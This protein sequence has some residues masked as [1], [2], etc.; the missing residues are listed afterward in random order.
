M[1]SATSTTTTTSRRSLHILLLGGSP[2]PAAALLLKENNPRQ[3]PCLSWST[4]L[5]LESSAR[6]MSNYRY[7]WW[8]WSQLLFWFKQHPISTERSISVA[9]FYVDSASIFLCGCSQHITCEFTNSSTYR[10]SLRL[11]LSRAPTSS[12]GCWRQSVWGFLFWYFF[13]AH[14]RSSQYC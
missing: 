11:H 5:M 10:D 8:C 9:G 2:I 13:E 12:N 6:R 4:M 14:E 7:P 1:W 3:Q